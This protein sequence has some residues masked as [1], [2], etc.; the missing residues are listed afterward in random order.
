M[1]ASCARRSRAAATS[2]MA[3]VIFCVDFTD[4]IRVRMLLS[5][6]ICRAPVSARPLGRLGLGRELLA[7]LTEHALHR[8]HETVPRLAVRPLGA[9]VVPELGAARVDVGVE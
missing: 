2:F 1:M 4:A 8:R 9:Q 6:G 5:E 7:E 3:R